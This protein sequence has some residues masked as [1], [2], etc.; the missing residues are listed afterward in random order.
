MSTQNN[1][2]TVMCA[3][4]LDFVD[5]P[6]I[7]GESAHR[8]FEKGALVIQNG[9]VV[10]LGYEQDILPSID[11]SATIIRHDGKLV[12]PGMIDTHIHLP[13]TEMVGAYGEQLLSWL[14]EYAFP[15]EKKVYL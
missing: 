9:K 3:N 14:T 4:I 15:T 12:M 2:I 6:A 13:Q 5:D 8:Y 11:K 7:A 10:N 1:K